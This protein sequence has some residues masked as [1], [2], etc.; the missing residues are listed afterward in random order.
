MVRQIVYQ[1]K[2]I[3]LAREGELYTDGLIACFGILGYF[4]KDKK[5]VLT[6]GHHSSLLLAGILPKWYNFTQ[7]HPEMS[8]YNTGRILVAKM[9]PEPEMPNQWKQADGRF[10][11]YGQRLDELLRGLRIQHPKAVVE[12]VDYASGS[13]FRSNL[14][15][16][17][18]ETNS[19]QGKL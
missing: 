3:K 18:W 9:N 16:L 7:E 12:A 8:V 13:H 2:E 15:D 5:V 1:D 11:T 10:L 17:T 4:E 14:D 19:V 6:M